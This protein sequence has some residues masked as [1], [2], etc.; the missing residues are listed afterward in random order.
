VVESFVA[1]F[2]AC[3]GWIACWC[4]DDGCCMHFGVCSVNFVGFDCTDLE[5]VDFLC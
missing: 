4:F 5:T 2:V 3:L 1:S